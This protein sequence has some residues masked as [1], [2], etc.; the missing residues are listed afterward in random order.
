MFFFC[1]RTKYLHTSIFYF[2]RKS[3]IENSFNVRLGGWKFFIFTYFFTTVGCLCNAVIDATLKL[4][5]A[6]LCFWCIL[7]KRG[8]VLRVLFF[9]SFMKHYRESRKK[10]SEYL[11]QISTTILSNFDSFLNY[12]HFF[13]RFYHNINNIIITKLKNI[14]MLP[15]R[16]DLS[17]RVS[18][19]S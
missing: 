15:E 11:K 4:V 19:G 14:Y 13:A 10:Q 3:Y 2:N 12:K 9:I 17:S 6:C 18:M 1:F 5:C 16:Y 8:F 7:T